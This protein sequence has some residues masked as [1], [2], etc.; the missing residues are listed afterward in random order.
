[1]LA[2]VGCADMP[3]TPTRSAGFDRLQAFLPDAGRQYAETRNYD[4]GPGR[5]NVSQLSPWLHTGLLREHE[6]LEATLREHGARAA[7]KFGNEIFWRVYFKGYL[8][9]RPSIWRS[10][11]QQRDTALTALDR[12]AGDRTAY[13]EATEGR[14]GIGAF[15]YWAQELIETGY[16]HNHARMW[17]A[18]I[19]IFTLKLD[20]TLGADFFLR[21]L[22]DGDA[23]SNT[24][25]WRWVGGLHTKGKTYLATKDNIA[26]YIGRHPDGPLDAEGLATDASALTEPEDHGRQAPDLPGPAGSESY[27]EPYALLL[28]DEAASHV[29]LDLPK[30]PALVIGAARPGARSPLPTA[31][32]LRSFARDA[33]ANGTEAARKAWSCPHA[34]WSPQTPLSDLLTPHGIDLVVTPFLPTGWTRDA[35]WPAL[36]PLAEEGRLVQV[37]P[38]L[39]RATWPHA[40]AGFFGVKKKIETAMREARIVGA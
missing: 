8:E 37:L 12:N 29:P 19:W 21:H 15:D 27:A 40:T 7:E 30:P 2:P 20:W 24:L 16:L 10:Y 14:T 26:R 39:Q 17:F 4:D 18:S 38:D 31:K 3:F 9:Q 34:E 1:M 13:E 36:A 6:V 23:A 11:C 28:H 5:G 32:P 25:S 35:L 22:V 33:V